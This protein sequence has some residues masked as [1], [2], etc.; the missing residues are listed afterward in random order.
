MSS[1][2]AVRVFLRDSVHVC[3]GACLDGITLQA[4]LRSDTPSVMYAN[5]LQNRISIGGQFT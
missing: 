2:R 3:C 1:Q 4:L 5:P